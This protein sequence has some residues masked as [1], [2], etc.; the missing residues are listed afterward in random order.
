MTAARRDEV[1]FGQVLAVIC[2]DS[3]MAQALSKLFSHVRAAETVRRVG[4][5]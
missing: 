1:Q 2:L 3:E 5:L 4:S